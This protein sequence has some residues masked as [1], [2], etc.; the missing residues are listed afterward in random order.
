MSRED[1]GAA[2]T[3]YGRAADAYVRRIKGTGLGLPVTKA[4]I[5]RH[6]GQM[7]IDSVPGKGTTVTCWFPPER[8]IT[9]VASETVGS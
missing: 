5:A 4:I 3:A 7:A 9:K 8:L 1:I 6:G 2:L